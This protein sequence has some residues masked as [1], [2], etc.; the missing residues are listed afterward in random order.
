MI[1]EL[2]SSATDQNSDNTGI[3]E[4]VEQII[5]QLNIHQR[6]VVENDTKT[7]YLHTLLSSLMPMNYPQVGLD[8][9]R[10]ALSLVCYE[11][12]LEVKCA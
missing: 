3:K 8:N 9:A 2:I 7:F 6:L 12:D 4:P 11:E 5:Q 10:T 1:A